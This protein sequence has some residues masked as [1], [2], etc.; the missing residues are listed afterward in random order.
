MHFHSRK[1]NLKCRLKNG[2]HFASAFLLGAVLRGPVYQ[3]ITKSDVMKAT[4]H[5]QN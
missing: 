4:K 2:V 5:N 1:C 3:G